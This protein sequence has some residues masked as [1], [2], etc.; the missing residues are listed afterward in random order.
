MVPTA[1]QVCSVLEGARKNKSKCGHR[2]DLE[3]ALLCE[4]W[5]RMARK[6]PRSFSFEGFSEAQV[7]E[8]LRSLR[9]ILPEELVNLPAHV[10]ADEL[11]ATLA[12]FKLMAQK[13]GREKIARSNLDGTTWEAE[14]LSDI[15][16]K[17]CVPDPEV[18][19]LPRSPSLHP[20]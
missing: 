17:A 8:K 5:G 4:Y 1:S 16:S 2:A 19:A 13:Q 11:G 9:R 10:P 3:R 12:S 7:K 6:A 20:C 18:R 15:N 14:T